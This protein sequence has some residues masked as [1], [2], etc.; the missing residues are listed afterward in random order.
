MRQVRR[1]LHRERPP[2][3]RLAARAG[4]GP[5]RAVGTRDLRGRDSHPVLH[6]AHRARRVALSDLAPAGAPRAVHDHRSGRVP[7]RD[8]PWRGRHG[9][10]RWFRD[11]GDAGACSRR[12]SLVVVLRPR[13]RVGGRARVHGHLFVFAGLAATAV[14]IELAIEEAT[15]AVLEGGA[16]AAL[17]GG[18]TLYLL[19]ITIVHPLSPAPPSTS[20]LAARLAVASFALVGTGLSPPVLTGMLTLAL[21]GLTVFEVAYAGWPGRASGAPAPR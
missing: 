1:R 18:V 11:G 9:V 6:A 20:A 3:E 13:R 8:R 2:L 4:A 19:S 12:V 21:A 15:H 17:C 16:K 5:L 7:S 14:G 10:G